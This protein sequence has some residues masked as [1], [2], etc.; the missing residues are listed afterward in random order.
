MEYY[1]LTGQ[2]KMDS[3]ARHIIDT[4]ILALIN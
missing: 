2:A 3:I 4:V 1:I